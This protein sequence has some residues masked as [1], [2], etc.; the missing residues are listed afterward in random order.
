MATIITARWS[1]RNTELE[2]GAEPYGLIAGTV[3]RSAHP[4]RSGTGGK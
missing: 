4:A 3:E 1:Y 2:F